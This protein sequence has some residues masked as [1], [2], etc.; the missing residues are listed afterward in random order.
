MTR[1]REPADRAFFYL[2]IVLTFAGFLIFFS[3]SLGLLGRE[4]ARFNLIAAKQFTIML[5]GLLAFLLVSKLHYKY[6]QKFSLAIFVAS[7][8]CTLAVFIP[9]IG[10]HLKGAQRWIVVAGISI[11]TSEFLKLGYV[12]YLAAWLSRARDRVQSI[13]HG[14]LPFLII[15]SIVGVVMVAQPDI[16][17]L[18][19]MLVAG[20]SMYFV[21][22]ARWRDLALLFL[23]AALVLS[24]VVYF[25]PYTQQRIKTFFNPHENVLGSSYQINQSLIAIG[26][27]GW[28]GRGFG[29]SIQ[30]FKFLPEPIGDSIFSVAGEEFGFV[31]SGLLLLLFLGLAL[32]GLK[33]SARAPNHF[34]RLLAVGIVIMMIA[35]VFI[36]I[37]SMLGLIPL[38]GTPLLFVS[39][40]GTALLLVL[41]EAGIIVNISKYLTR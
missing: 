18:G 12:V 2:V 7:L 40:G 15:T 1:D 41:I 14:L 22:G 28:T 27:G 26:S 21:A 3:A 24:V 16:S 37:A 31:G 34:S 29:Q 9:D 25:K 39:Q 38:N 4:G 8:L 17:T 10:L 33:V 11:Q 13:K 5:V 35:G 30:K 6:W 23:T 32:T 36:N 19:I 20:A